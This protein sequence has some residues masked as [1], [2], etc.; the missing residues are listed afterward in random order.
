MI[1]HR[2]HLLCACPAAQRWTVQWP[3][4][5]EMAGS[6]TRYR[7]RFG[8]AVHPFIAMQRRRS[9]VARCGRAVAASAER[10]AEP[11]A[12]RCRHKRGLG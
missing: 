11:A 7:V 2:W 8:G 9:C 5:K 3:V 10:T 6:F 1:L 4:F 12:H